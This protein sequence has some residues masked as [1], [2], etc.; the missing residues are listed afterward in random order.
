MDQRVNP[1]PP[2]IQVLR[3]FCDMWSEHTAGC[4]QC[5]NRA[6]LPCRMGRRILE[7][8]QEQAK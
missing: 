1:P 8:L 3:D 2:T 7:G 6:Y 4:P 5:N